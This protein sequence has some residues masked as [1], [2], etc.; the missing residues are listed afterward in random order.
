MRIFSIFFILSIILGA[1]SNSNPTEKS[2]MEVGTTPV[3][4]HQSDIREMAN[5]AEIKDFKIDN[6]ILSLNKD[7]YIYDENNPLKALNQNI[8]KKYDVLYVNTTN[9]TNQIKDFDINSVMAS[10]NVV[11][12]VVSKGEH[13]NKKHMLFKVPKQFMRDKSIHIVDTKGHVLLSN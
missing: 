8:F 11:T 7:I 1:C 13:Y 4:V 6:E 3:K 5:V 9:I 10:E 12:I 2:S